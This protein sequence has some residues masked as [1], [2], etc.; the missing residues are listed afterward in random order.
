LK[1]LPELSGVALRP[2]MGVLRCLRKARRP[3]GPDTLAYSV[4]SR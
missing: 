2:V 1:Y 3:P 4:F